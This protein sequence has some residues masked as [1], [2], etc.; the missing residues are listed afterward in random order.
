MAIEPRILEV[1]A[2]SRDIPI[3]RLLS[4]SDRPLGV[5]VIAR[6]LGLVPTTCLH[7]LRCL[8]QSG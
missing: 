4:V 2:L 6:V 5:H 8:P 3:L 7:I 1:P